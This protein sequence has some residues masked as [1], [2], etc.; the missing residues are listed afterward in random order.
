MRGD[1]GFSL[2]VQY[3][4]PNEASPVQRHKSGSSDTSVYCSFESHVCYVTEKKKRQQRMNL[5]PKQT[6]RKSV[7]STL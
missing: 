2:V 6:G 4:C 7:S 1:F 3:G 5:F